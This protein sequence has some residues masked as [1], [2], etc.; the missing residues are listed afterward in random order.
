MPRHSPRPGGSRFSGAGKS[1][2]R[3]RREMTIPIRAPWWKVL[4]W[5]RLAT[6]GG[7]S[8]YPGSPPSDACAR[9][10][11]PSAGCPLGRAAGCHPASH[12]HAGPTC[13]SRVSR[14]GRMEPLFLDRPQ[15]QCGSFCD[16]GDPSAPNR[17]RGIGASVLARANPGL[18]WLARRV[19]FGEQAGVTSRACREWRRGTHECVRH[20]AS[21]LCEKRRLATLVSVCFAIWNKR[22]KKS[23]IIAVAIRTA[24]STYCSHK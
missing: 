12:K 5:G 6:C 4:M 23:P 2:P 7:P 16:A 22:S 15:A 8:G 9:P 21:R 18:F 20:K 1:R 10:T 17:R 3:A 14:A 24:D 19:G 13:I 11:R